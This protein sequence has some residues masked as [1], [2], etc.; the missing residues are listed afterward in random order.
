MHT[1]RRE[2]D[3]RD[4][5]MT[6]TTRK[7]EVDRQ[8]RKTGR[9]DEAE[10]NTPPPKITTHR[11]KQ[12]HVM[13][14][15][16][17]SYITPQPNQPSTLDPPTGRPTRTHAMHMHMQTDRQ[18]R[19]PASQPARRTDRQPA[20]SPPAPTGPQKRT[21]L[22]VHTYIRKPHSIQRDRYIHRKESDGGGGDG[23]TAAR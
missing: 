11:K 14:C 6:T 5:R 21:P 2:R 22:Q 7:R 13:L 9:R 8:T 4:I 19:Q 17:C 15:F 12:I 16:N 1:P 10:K 20:S 3:K 23:T 18:G